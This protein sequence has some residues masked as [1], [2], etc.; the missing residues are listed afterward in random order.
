MQLLQHFSKYYST[1]LQY[2]FT[3]NSLKEMC[4]WYYTNRRAK[5]YFVKCHHHAGLQKTKNLQTNL[6]AQSCKNTYISISSAATD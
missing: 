6:S 2:S 3:E 4:C 1:Y 5:Q